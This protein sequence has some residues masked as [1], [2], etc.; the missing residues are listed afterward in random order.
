M[1]HPGRRLQLQPPG[2]PRSANH[3]SNAAQVFLPD[4]VYVHFIQPLHDHEGMYA[5]TTATVTK[6]LALCSASCIFGRH[7]TLECFNPHRTR[8]LPH[9]KRV[10]GDNAVKHVY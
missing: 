3:F 2:E 9:G 6:C 10:S 5:R 7:C 1:T 8:A 4:K